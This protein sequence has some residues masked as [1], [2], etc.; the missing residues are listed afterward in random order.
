MRFSCCNWNRNRSCICINPITFNSDSFFSFLFSPF[1]FSFSFFSVI[2]F[3]GKSTNPTCSRSFF[4]FLTVSSS[5]SIQFTFS[6][7]SDSF[8]T[9][10]FSSSRSSW[11]WSWSWWCSICCCCNTASIKKKNW[12][13]DDRGGSFV[14]VRRIS[15]GL[16]RG[17]AYHSSS[18]I[19]FSLSVNVY[20][21]RCWTFS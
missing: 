5:H 20:S 10:R 18:G 8:I 15:Q 2:T 9:L 6:R 21:F 3:P 7:S 19:Q 16:D 17:N 12:K 11:W 13:M 4:H 14:A 1:S